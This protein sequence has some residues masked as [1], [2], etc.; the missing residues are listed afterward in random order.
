[1]RAQVE[2]TQRA[3]EFL[4]NRLKRSLLGAGW[5]GRMPLV[6]DGPCAPLLRGCRGQGGVPK[7]SHSHTFASLHEPGPVG[8]LPGKRTEL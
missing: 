4:L 6:G 1:M 7:R 5:G 8:R 2:E 3:G